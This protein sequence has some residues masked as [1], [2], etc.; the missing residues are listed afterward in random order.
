M[1]AKILKGEA[2]ASEMPFETIEKP[3]LYLNSK[4]AKDLGI[5]L[6]KDLLDRA[7]ENITEVVIPQEK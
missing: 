7:T 2:K 6:P 5:E 1:A 4:V 3:N